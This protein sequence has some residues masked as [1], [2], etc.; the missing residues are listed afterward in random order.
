MGGCQLANIRRATSPFFLARFNSYHV[1]RHCTIE[2]T[3][4]GMRSQWKFL[5][6]RLL[7]RW[8]QCHDKYD[9]LHL[10]R[11]HIKLDSSF[12]SSFHT[13]E[14]HLSST[15]PSVPIVQCIKILNICALHMHFF[16]MHTLMLF[17]GWNICVAWRQRKLRWRIPELKMHVGRFH[18]E[19]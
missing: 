6:K 4:E 19:I 2:T 15:L 16:N 7:A 3:K 10:P 5:R 13:Y 12:F 14:N 9:T 11:I 18:L 17:S 1:K 8:I